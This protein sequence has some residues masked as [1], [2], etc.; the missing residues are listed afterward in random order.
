MKE[1]GLRFLA[2][3]VLVFGMVSVG[4]AEV[5]KDAIANLDK[6]WQS[7]NV[8]LVEKALKTFE[9]AAKKDAKDPMA[10]YYVAKAHFT[11]ADALDIK[12]EKEFDQTGFPLHPRKSPLQNS[13]NS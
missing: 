8:A 6:G 12:S 2:V 10:P 5:P 11:I 1:K 7:L 4:L 9:E 13:R 3:A